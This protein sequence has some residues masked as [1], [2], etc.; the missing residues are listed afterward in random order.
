M[1]FICLV[2]V[3]PRVCGCS[4]AWTPSR[5]TNW[6][7]H[8]LN[9]QFNYL[10]VNILLAMTA[11]KPQSPNQMLGFRDLATANLSTSSCERSKSVNS[12]RPKRTG[13]PQKTGSQ[14]NSSQESDQICESQASRQ[15]VLLLHGNKVQ[16]TGTPQKQEN[17]IKVYEHHLMDRS[18]KDQE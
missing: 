8:T 5:Q 1:W 6:H 14:K 15:R 7:N 4:G 18:D 3:S 17:Q 9:C 10:V 11:W 2:N 13:R 16:T 12:G